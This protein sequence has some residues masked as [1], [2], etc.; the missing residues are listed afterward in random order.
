[1]KLTGILT[2]MVIVA[3]GIA[4]YITHLWW[5]VSMLFGDTDM[6]IKDLALALLGAFFPPI[7]VIHGV[8]IWF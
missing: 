1:M 7:G 3:G 2:A 4:A 6:A 5:T 8:I